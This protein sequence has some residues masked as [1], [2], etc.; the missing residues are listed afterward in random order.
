VGI[1]DLDVGREG[2]AKTLILPQARGRP[3]E[4]KCLVRFCVR[5]VGDTGGSIHLA[6]GRSYR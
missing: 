4:N 2:R 6:C 5:R 1:D 3:P